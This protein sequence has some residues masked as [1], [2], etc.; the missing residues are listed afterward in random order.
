[1]REDSPATPAERFFTLAQEAT[2][3][4]HYTSEIGLMQDLEH[5][6]ETDVDGPETS[7]PADALPASQGQRK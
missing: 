7:C 5:Q 3:N 1:M 4:G 6:G 2:V